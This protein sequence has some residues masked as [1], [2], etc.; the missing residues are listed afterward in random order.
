[1]ENKKYEIIYKH[2]E[3][4]LKKHGLNHKG[5]DWPKEE[6]LLK[7]FNVMY[8]LFKYDKRE[9]GSVLDL[10]CGI[11][12]FLNYIENLKSSFKI[13]YKGID[14]SE[15]MIKG[16]K[17]INKEGD[18]EVRDVLIQPLE[19]NQYDYII[20]NGLMTEKVSLKQEEM[21]EFAQNIISVAFH[22]ANIGIAF[23]VMSSHVDW[24]RD[25]LFHW[26]LDE[27]VG[28]LVKNCSRH[29][30]INMDYGLYEYTVYVYKNSNY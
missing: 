18:F 29:V 16:A 8:D 4:T 7:R 28:F 5:M 25:D 20:M 27:L 12:L 15:E 30:K 24:K 2:Y 21:I 17:A 14:I 19:K 1:M 3:N 11:G 10:G 13:N 6:D 26:E 22:A 23:N 9:I